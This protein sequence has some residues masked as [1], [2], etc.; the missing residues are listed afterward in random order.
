MPEEY[1]PLITLAGRD[2]ALA[3]D[4]GGFTVDITHI[5]VG[6]VGWAVQTDS[7]GFATAT[8]L[9]SERQRVA[10]QH[11]ADVG[12]GQKDISVVLDRPIDHD[13]SFFVREIGFFLADGTLFAI[14]SNPNVSLL[15]VGPEQ[16]HAL[17]LELVL[18]AVDPE[19]VNV[20]SHGPP[21]ELLMTDEISRLL[22]GQVQNAHRLFQSWEAH[23]AEHRKY[24]SHG[25]Y[26]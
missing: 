12:G 23:Y 16:D 15:W 4:V 13:S 3:A 21:L 26:T 11:A 24:P 17:A 18:G 10:I 20:V 22:E 8:E 25:D 2:A 14:A 9:Q 19:N 6:D 1:I 5:A 7:S